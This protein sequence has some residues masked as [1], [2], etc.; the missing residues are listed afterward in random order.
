MKASLSSGPNNSET[1]LGRGLGGAAAWRAA[2]M[3]CGGGLARSRRPR[4]AA[5]S[6]EEPPS[7]AP[8]LLPHIHTQTPQPQA[9]RQGEMPAARCGESWSQVRAEAGG[10]CGGEDR[11]NHGSQRHPLRCSREPDTGHYCPEEGR[12]TSRE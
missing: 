10:G 6:S 7:P 11:C 4:P 12:E 5:I 1:L 9:A 3:N 2:G 8:R